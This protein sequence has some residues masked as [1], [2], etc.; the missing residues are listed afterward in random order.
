ME[1]FLGVMSALVVAVGYLLPFALLASLALVV[2]RLLHRSS[3]IGART[4]DG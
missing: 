2:Y 3:R 1:G 4:A